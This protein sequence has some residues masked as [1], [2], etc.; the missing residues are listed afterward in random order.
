[1]GKLDAIFAKLKNKQANGTGSQITSDGTPESNNNTKELADLNH[2]ISRS[3]NVSTSSSPIL[4][5]SS[6]RKSRKSKPRNIAE[7]KGGEKYEK[8]EISEY[9]INNQKWNLD[10]QNGSDIDVDDQTTITSSRPITPN[11]PNFYDVSS[12]YGSTLQ[13]DSL[14][15]SQDADKL[16]IDESF[17]ND[18]DSIPLDLT[19]SKDTKNKQNDHNLTAD[20]NLDAAD[21]R[22]TADNQPS[23]ILHS[24][25]DAK[26]LNSTMN[27]LLKMYGLGGNPTET[28]DKLQLT[29]Y[30]VAQLAATANLG[31]IPKI[32]ANNHAVAPPV[33]NGHFSTPKKGLF[34]NPRTPLLLQNGGYKSSAKPISSPSFTKVSSSKLPGLKSLGSSKTL[35]PDYTK[36]L[37]RFSNG[38]QCGGS[39]CKELGYRE[40]YHCLDCC[41]VYVKKEEMVRHFKWH[42]KREESLQHGFMRYSPMDNCQS[43]FGICTHNG[44]QTHYHCLQ[45]GCD[46]VYI[47]TSDVQMH[48]NYHRKDSAIILEGFQ[49]FRATEDCGTPSCQ[50]YG[51]RTTHFHCRRATCNFTFKNKADME[52]HKTYHQKD[53]ILSKDGFKKFMKYE[54]CMFKNCKYTKISNH[55]HCIRPGCDYVLHST[56]QLYSHKRKHER[57]EF[58]SAYQN[59]RTTQ[60]NG[61]VIN[62]SL[63][64]GQTGQL[65]TTTPVA[66]S[67]T[68][69]RSVVQTVTTMSLPVT[70]S[71]VQPIFQQ[72][73]TE[74]GDSPSRETTEEE[75]NEEEETEEKSVLKNYSD[76]LTGEKLNDSLTLPI[77]KLEVKSDLTHKTS[78]KTL[79]PIPQKDSL[80]LTPDV[81]RSLIDRRDKDDSWKNYLIR[82]TANDP[83][84]S[85]CVLLYKDHYH[86]HVE[87]CNHLFRGKDGVREHSKY[88]EQQD[89]ISPLVYESFDADEDCS[90]TECQFNGNKKH[91]HC[92][93]SG[94]NHVIDGESNMFARLEHYRIHE[95]AK[96]SAGRSSRSSGLGS[97]DKFDDDPS[98]RRRG[99]PPKYPRSVIP[100]VPKVNLSDDEI[101]DS[102]QRYLHGEVDES[103]K[104]FNGFQ[105]F[106]E[107]E[108]CPDDLCLYAGK[109]HYHCARNRCY[110]ATD[111]LDVLNLHAK[112]FHSFVTI[113]DGYEF[114]DRNVNCRRNHCHNNK[115]NR[116]FHCTRPGCDYS[117]VRHSTMTQHEKK[118]NQAQT[119][120]SDKISPPIKKTTN[121]VPIVPA[122]PASIELRNKNIVKSAGT[123]YPLSGLNNPTFVS[124]SLPNMISVGQPNFVTSTLLSP[125]SSAATLFPIQGLSLV[126]Q[127]IVPTS[128]T[129]QTL[130]P[131]TMPSTETSTST[132]PVLLQQQQVEGNSENPES[133][134]SNL[135][136]TMHFSN[137]QNCCRPF[138]KLKKK[139][140][141]HCIECNQAFSDPLRLRTHIQK[142]GIKLKRGP[143]S[144]KTDGGLDLSSPAKRIRCSE[145]V[146]EHGNGRQDEADLTSS[147]L[148]LDPAVFSSMWRSEEMCNENKIKLKREPDDSLA[149]ID[150]EMSDH[151]NVDDTDG[152]PTDLSKWSGRKRTATKHEDFID[153]DIVAPKVPKMSSPRIKQEFDNMQEGYSRYRFNED[154]EYMKCAY[155]HSSTHYHCLRSDCGYGFSDRSRLIQHTVRHE[156]IDKIMGDEFRQFR[157]S[158]HCTKNNCE[159]SAKSSHFHCLKCPFSCADSSKVSAHRKHH[160]KLD[161]ISSKGFVKYIGSQDCEV[162]FCA[163]SKK[164][165]HY[166]CTFQNCNHA[167]LGPA[168]MAPH[169]LKHSVK[170]KE[171]KHS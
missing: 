35:L 52:K 97:L 159:F 42:K 16:V 57:R 51:Q 21:S 152:S 99:R 34:S 108:T 142:H 120:D 40:H 168:Q 24:T 129:M 162:P 26:L 80:T 48:A 137:N 50:F 154:C 28:P 83:C 9:E 39:H 17:D 72:S 171:E 91:H 155:K 58:E 79:T 38:T 143:S 67:S 156:R 117:F 37:K 32:P 92:N 3:S 158:V 109:E 118:H 8:E 148:N 10:S 163:H 13:P 166:H 106:E 82:Y 54:S 101:T 95:Y 4:S 74:E 105:K 113:L 75:D 131:I 6:R 160:L 43:K 60:R 146:T 77:P 78:S 111:R 56:A 147:S 121:F 81:G 135:R 114:F 122:T 62:K 23:P 141:Y 2:D 96:V 130:V 29:K 1:M 136:N 11:S 69:P 89:R 55:I 119:T 73:S 61:P 116:H 49:R 63:S 14:E 134:W 15:N 68:V 123:F 27:E 132:L 165:T 140:H 110:H 59:F 103:S 47:S 149:S 145:T 100:S 151:S 144:T 139:D 41:K 45:N 126:P 71:P 104:I 138:C 20:N 153:S 12:D 125:S 7:F 64:Q 115:A 164:Q 167:V 112:D 46:K 88:H 36:Y 102:V 84:N 150:S 22:T 25:P 87:G 127:L 98:K 90:R 124:V 170:I 53:E 5:G 44:R 70:I 93:W 169:K 18:N 86:C 85:R 31:L 30:H 66:V 94:C 157:A 76:E 65:V 33:L 133:S 19:V 161:N 107:N 128:P